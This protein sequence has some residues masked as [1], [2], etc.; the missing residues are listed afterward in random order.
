MGQVSHEQADLLLKLYDLRREAKL[1]EARSWFMSEFSA[2]SPEE[3]GNAT[4]AQLTHYGQLFRQAKSRPIDI[5]F[6]D[7]RIMSD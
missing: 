3:L 5:Q 2:S 7:S 6:P 4:R 1:R